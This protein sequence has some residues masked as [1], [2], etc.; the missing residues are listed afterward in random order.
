MAEEKTNL[1][2]FLWVQNKEVQSV[3]SAFLLQGESQASH[4]FS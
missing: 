4:E 2:D 3:S 1:R